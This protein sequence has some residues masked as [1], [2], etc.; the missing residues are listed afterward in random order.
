MIWRFF[1]IA[2]RVAIAH[3]D[4]RDF[5]LGAVGI[6]NDGAIVKASNGPVVMIDSDR[7]SSYPAAHAE[8]RLSRKLDKG[9]IVFVCRIKKGNKSFGLARPC[10][11]CQRKLAAKGVKKVYYTINDHEYGVLFLNLTNKRYE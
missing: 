9:S 11:D 6:R 10:K 1:A 5:Y 4:I 8:F 2:R 7:K 3:D